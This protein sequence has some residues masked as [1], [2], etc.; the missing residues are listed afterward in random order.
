MTSEA[1]CNAASENKRKS[2]AANAKKRRA[3]RE[4]PQP[5]TACECH[6]Q[7]DQRREHRRQKLC[8]LTNTCKTFR[9]QSANMPT[10]FNRQGRSGSGDAPAERHNSM[11]EGRGTTA[12]QANQQVK[13]RHRAPLLRK[14]S[15]TSPNRLAW[16]ADTSDRDPDCAVALRAPLKE[17]GGTALT[18]MS[19]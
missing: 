7:F 17:C 19:P 1:W 4:R 12:A 18:A 11:P 3:Q 15:N 8:R 6:R 14:T 5:A 9:S 10:W 2:S 13:K 16:L